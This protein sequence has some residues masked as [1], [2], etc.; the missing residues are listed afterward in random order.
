MTRNSHQHIDEVFDHQSEDEEQVRQARRAR[1][2]AAQVRVDEAQVT[3][4][5]VHAVMTLLTLPT[6]Q[7]VTGKLSTTDENYS[8]AHEH[9]ANI[10][11]R[12]P[13]RNVDPEP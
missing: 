13:A 5:G 2:R 12:R 4:D 8:N 3:E 11:V 7:N 9:C 10:P 1:S 6:G